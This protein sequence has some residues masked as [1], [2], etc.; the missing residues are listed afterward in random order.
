MNKL[1]KMIAPTVLMLLLLLL[2]LSASAT[3][4]W[5]TSFEDEQL[6]KIVESTLQNNGD[7][8]SMHNAL[9]QMEAVESLSKSGM[10][11]MLSATASNTLMPYDAPVYVPVDPNAP[12]TFTTGGVYL[13]AQ[14]SLTSLGK[15]RNSG[16][17]ATYQRKALQKDKESLR[18]NLAVAITMSYLELVFQ[19]QAYS[20]VETQ[21]K[22][23]EDALELSKRR[24]RAG[25]T[26]YLHVLQ[27]EQNLA[28]LRTQLPGI[29]SSIRGAKQKLAA[30]S[31]IPVKSLEVND[32]LP[33]LVDYKES[34]IQEIINTR[35]DIQGEE[36]RLQSAEYSLKAAK[37]GFLPS[38]DFTGRYGYDYTNINEP[39]W[40][41]TW[42]LGVNVTVPLFTGFA[43]SSSVKEARA[44]KESVAN[45]LSQTKKDASA[46]LIAILN[47]EEDQ[48]ESWAAHST[49]VQAAR[50]A[51]NEAKLQY[52][53][54]LVGYT[55]VLNSLNALQMSE[56]NALRAHYSALIT[57]V[58]AIQIR[59]GKI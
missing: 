49:H 2:P 47:Q 20:L 22:A 8:K 24:F 45:S 21:I 7:W 56:T 12:E 33:G 25:E 13:N 43:T 10:Y 39:D 57:R 55:D 34:N 53:K 23:S 3:E 50:K 9:E 16:H 17:S 28:S 18:T 59:G 6:N 26:N 48:M 32:S 42:A 11:P 19:K 27:Q 37:W 44:A 40:D 29:R 4:N 54:G 36:L 41:D 15:T 51:Y 14:Y 5:W 52:V 58:Q 1:W 35:A 30:Y 38:I 46:D 31:G